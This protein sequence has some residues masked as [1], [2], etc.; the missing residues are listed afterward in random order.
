MPPLVLDRALHL[1]GLAASAAL[2]GCAAKPAPP[3][4]AQQAAYEQRLEKFIRDSALIDSLARPVRTDSL[5]RL[6]RLALRPSGTDSV[7]LNAIGRERLRIG[8]IHGNVPAL[9]RVHAML[10][11]VFADRGIHEWRKA[12]RFLLSSAPRT[13][14]VSTDACGRLPPNIGDVVNGTH[15]DV[16]PVRPRPP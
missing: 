4:P 9:R 16:E 10:D 12:E 13:F 6:Y 14:I 5:Y 3:T 11:T 1:V 7:L 2:G 8:F 15:I